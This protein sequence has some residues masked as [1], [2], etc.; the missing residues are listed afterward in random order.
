MKTHCSTNDDGKVIAVDTKSHEG[1]LKKVI[2]T[3][4]I[5]QEGHFAISLSIY[6]MCCLLTY[7]HISAL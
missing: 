5:A 7:F 4:N 1:L 3:R 6:A 2:N